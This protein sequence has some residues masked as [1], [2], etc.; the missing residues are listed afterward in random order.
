MWGQ[1]QFDRFLDHI[2]DPE[3]GLALLA[4][5]P[6]KETP[7]QTLNRLF[8]CN[9]FTQWRDWRAG[10][11][12]AVSRA[13]M[14]CALSNRRPPTWLCKAVH[15]LCGQCMPDKD[16]RAYGDLAKHV[17]R[18]RAVEVVRGRYKGDPRNYRRKVQSDDI[19]PEAAK[20]V[21][22]TNAEADAET[23][24]KSHAL[25]RRAGG[26][27]VTL[28]SYRRKVRKRERRRKK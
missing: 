22:G 17:Q 26:H 5:H 9:Q 6:N 15:E 8:W 27:D 19:W 13:Q 12:L 23:V 28:Q 3:T 14:S 24:G 25:I 10:D 1:Q 11:V 18:W 4:K 7:E 21:A 16:K 20:L 2:E